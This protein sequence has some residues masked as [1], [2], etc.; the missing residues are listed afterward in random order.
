MATHSSV[1]AWRIPGTGSLV[2]CRLW[3]R[4]ESA[5]LKWLSSSSI[6]AHQLPRYFRLIFQYCAPTT[7]VPRW[8]TEVPTGPITWMCSF[9]VAW[10]IERQPQLQFILLFALMK[11]WKH[12]IAK[13]ARYTASDTNS[14]LLTASG[15]HTQ[16]KL[17]HQK[18]RLNP[19]VSKTER[20]GA[21]FLS[22]KS[23]PGATV[24]SPTLG[25]LCSFFWQELRGSH[26]YGPS[27][28]RNGSQQTGIG[29]IKK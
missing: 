13:M 11:C 5:R 17:R 7:T 10:F 2:G 20:P 26:Q 4:T 28:F 18:Q 16:K 15:I 21:V 29:R 19:S 14:F 24:L 27:N 8:G 22:Q 6:I 1:F 23:G 12:R 25:T 9:S 3:G